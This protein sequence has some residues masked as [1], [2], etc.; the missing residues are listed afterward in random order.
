M[1][2]NEP[3]IRGDA[4]RRTLIPDSSP[5][6]IGPP[7]TAAEN[8]PQSAGNLPLSSIQVSDSN[9][10]PHDP[11]ETV[12]LKPGTTSLPVAPGRAKQPAGQA[13]LPQLAGYE[14]LELIAQGGMG[15]VYRAR[16][17]KLHRPVAIKLPRGGIINSP[18]DKERFFRE[19]RASAR[20]RHPNICPIYEVREVNGE[21]C[22]CMAFIAG[23]TLKQWVQQQQCDPRQI[24]ELVATLATAVQFAHDQGVLHRD[25]KPA[26]VLVEAHNGQPLLM[27][28]GLAKDLGQEE[29]LTAS[30]AVLGTPAYMAP[31]QAGGRA[32]LIGKLS[33][34]Y[35]LGVILYELL[36]GAPPFRG[37]VAEILVKVQ[38]E[39]PVTLRKLNSQLHPDL[40]TICQKAMAKIPAERYATAADLA[41]DLQRFARGEPIVAK[42]QPWHRRAA[43][44]I[45]KNRTVAILT[46]SLVLVLVG[47]VIAL[48]ELNRHLN[49]QLRVSRLSNQLQIQLKSSDWRPSQVPAAVQLL[50]DLETLSPPDAQAGQEFLEL[51]LNEYIEER[52]KRGSSLSPTDVTEIEADIEVLKTLNVA[53]ATKQSEQLSRQSK[54]WGR[55]ATLDNGFADSDKYLP[56]TRIKDDRSALLGPPNW[57]DPEFRPKSVFLTPQEVDGNIQLEGRVKLP[58]KCSVGFIIA[59]TKRHEACVTAIAVSPAGEHFASADALGTLRLFQTGGGED[60]GSLPG[61]AGAIGGLA[62][63]PDGKWL[64]SSG[65][66]GEVHVIDF[67]SKKIAQMWRIEV[68]PGDQLGSYAMFFGP[69]LAFNADGSQLL[70]GSGDGRASGEIRR[71]KFPAGP[72]LP[73]LRPAKPTPFVVQLATSA[74]DRVA[75]GTWDNR[76]Q[77]WDLATGKQTVDH[78]LHPADKT[79]NLPAL[80]LHP[81]GNV[82]A[83]AAHGVIHLINEQGAEFAQ[84]EGYAAGVYALAFDNDGK[85]LAA[86]HEAGTIKLWDVGLR[87]LKHTIPDNRRR[88]ETLAFGP[89][90][91]FL[92]GG[93]EHGTLHFWE[94]PGGQERYVIDGKGYNFLAS[95]AQEG[96]V[97]LQITRG[98]TVLRE[99]VIQVDSDLLQFRARREGDRLELQVDR[100][101]P[102]VFQD[103]FPPQSLTAGRWGVVLEPFTELQQLIVR[104]SQVTAAVNPLQAGDRLLSGGQYAGALEAFE[105]E[106]SNPARDP[107][108]ERA[109]QEA[110][111]KAAICLV[112]LG[113]EDQ[114]AVKLRDMSAGPTDD[115]AVVMARFLLWEMLIR[116]EKRGEADKLFAVTKIDLP[117]EFVAEVIP[118][119][120]RAR[121][122]ALYAGPV[123]RRTGLAQAGTNLHLQIALDMNEYFG[124]PEVGIFDWRM[125]ALATLRLSGQTEKLESESARV[126][127]FLDEE[128]RRGD[129]RLQPIAPLRLFLRRY[130]AIARLH[131]EPERVANYLKV[132]LLD[133]NGDLLPDVVGPRLALLLELARVYAARGEWQRAHDTLQPLLTE[134]DQSGIPREFLGDAALLAGFALRHL[135]READALAAWRQHPYPAITAKTDFSQLPSTEVLQFW[136]LRSLAG[137]LTSLEAEGIIAVIKQRLAGAGTDASELTNRVPIQPAVLQQAWQ[138]GPGQQTAKAIALGERLPAEVVAD[139]MQVGAFALFARGAF[140][141]PL[142]ADQEA[143]VWQL[144]QNGY[145]SYAN[146]EI[147]F[148]TLSYVGVAWTPLLPP[149]STWQSLLKPL[150]ESTRAS[151]AYVL[152]RRC[153]NRGKPADARTL[154]GLARDWAGDDATLKRLADEELTQLPP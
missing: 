146:G 149:L 56:G 27:D 142:T 86:G 51:R 34:V 29:G 137:D 91:D 66:D 12:S 28:F 110:R 141:G 117:R 143:V 120:T 38:S 35:A 2:D 102:L 114:A 20:L 129:I 31:E 22:I 125:T 92:V 68:P 89:R 18:E 153:G 126:L 1:P 148:V 24:A 101:P 147:S 32:E 111:L 87:Q 23:L 107:A 96:P 95:R 62:F 93:V 55:L 48:P 122:L 119:D 94:L 47:F 71:W 52:L 61:H 133:S 135:G 50:K 131:G 140:P 151:G 36:S 115:P 58:P 134:P 121:I 78:T 109:R 42:R 74:N 11:P 105:R 4:S 139:C 123:F 118:R 127:Q 100:R 150:P 72:E 37:T 54:V 83:A 104:R 67:A 57:I 144:T 10:A 39:E 6:P 15:V 103:Y 145:R 21:P 81:A 82:I 49:R 99:Q 132:V 44:L 53:L 45:A 97:T 69:P 154:F 113:R 80:A 128:A 19:A 70:V 43:R 79:P 40:E 152:G 65:T 106:E 84:L 16:D 88:C 30:G 73:A 8:T 17:L 14:V 60:L 5:A 76:A 25:L 85:T 64:A 112:R 63:S 7:P 130:G 138:S 77:L 75:A 3:S 13:R 116:Q 26:N 98:T 108:A 124:L 9:L 46:A 59:A 33:D 136:M 41:A 90:G